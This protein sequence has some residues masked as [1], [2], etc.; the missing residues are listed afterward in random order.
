MCLYPAQMRCVEFLLTL[1]V[2]VLFMPQNSLTRQF[3]ASVSRLTVSPLPPLCKGR[4]TASAV[5]GLQ[6]RSAVRA[7]NQ[8][9]TNYDNPSVCLRRQLPLHRGAKGGGFYA[10]RVVLTRML[11]ATGNP[12]LPHKCKN[13]GADLWLCHCLPCVRGGGP[14]A[15]VGLQT[16]SA[17]RAYN[18]LRT[19]YDN[20]SV[21]LRRQLPLHRGAKDMD[22]THAVIFHRGD[23]GMASTLAVLLFT[24][25]AANYHTANTQQAQKTNLKFILHYAR[26]YILVLCL[27]SLS[28]VICLMLFVLCLMLLVA[29]CSV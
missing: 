11:A 28:Y 4:G 23:K 9:R 20:P 15:V 29:F 25:T 2:C 8:L 27:M 6:T 24:H 16:R 14:F 10:C 19:N 18:Q 1:C 7:Y 12:S 21:C 5:V 13:R 22:I 17:V 26:V 3:G